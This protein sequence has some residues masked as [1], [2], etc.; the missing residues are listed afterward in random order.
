MYTY[1][2]HDGRPAAVGAA[3]FRAVRY[4]MEALGRMD[5]F[6]PDEAVFHRIWPDPD[7][8]APVPSEVQIAQLT[9]EL[10]AAREAIADLTRQL[11]IAEGEIAPLRFDLEAALRTI[12]DLRRGDTIPPA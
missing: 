3:R 10:T 7:A 4:E 2:N 5:A 12:E 8:V 6:T 9:T 11:A 1:I